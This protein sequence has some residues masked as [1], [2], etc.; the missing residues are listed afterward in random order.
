MFRDGSLI[1]QLSPTL[2]GGT[3]SWTE[4]FIDEDDWTPGSLPSGDTIRRKRIHW[5]LIEQ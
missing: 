3:L 4:G 1:V 5:R 2:G